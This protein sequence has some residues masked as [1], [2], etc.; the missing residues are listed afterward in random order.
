MPTNVT[1][2]IY[3]QGFLMKRVGFTMIELI[4]VIVILGILAAVA[5]PKLSAT[6]DD[7]KLVKA[8]GE[9]SQAIT[10]IGAYYTAHGKMGTS[11]QMTN[12]KFD[13]ENMSNGVN[14]EVGAAVN[15]VKFKTTADGN[16]TVEDGDGSSSF[17][18]KVR[19]QIAANDLN[20][21]HIFGG[22]SV[23]F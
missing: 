7:A 22:T 4:F 1:K 17:C 5:I 20:G 13:D 23:S 19:N 15:C 2:K 9:I 21:S 14:Y 8:A 6:R 3:T 10:D 18:T 11:K 12:V 16:L